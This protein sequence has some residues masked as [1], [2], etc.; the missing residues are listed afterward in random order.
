MSSGSDELKLALEKLAKLQRTNTKEIVEIE[1]LKS[2]NENTTELQN[3]SLTTLKEIHELQVQITDI[4]TKQV[5]PENTIHIH[6]PPELSTVERE[7]TP[8][9]KQSQDF[10]DPKIVIDQLLTD[11]EK[12]EQDAPVH[13]IIYKLPADPMLKPIAN[14][15]SFNAEEKQSIT[16]QVDAASTIYLLNQMITDAQR[17]EWLSKAVI[18]PLKQLSLNTEMSERILNDESLKKAFLNVLLYGNYFFGYEKNQTEKNRYSKLFKENMLILDK[19]LGS[20]NIEVLLKA[21]ADSKDLLRM[22]PLA[23]GE[24]LA[25]D[26]LLEPFRTAEIFGHYIPYLVAENPE[27]IKTEFQILNQEDKLIESYKIKEIKVMTADLEGKLIRDEG[28]MGSILVPDNLETAEEPTVYICFK[29]TDSTATALADIQIRAGAESYRKSERQILEQIITELKSYQAQLPVGK[30]LKIVLAGHSLGGAY[31]QLCFTSLQRILAQEIAASDEELKLVLDGI[32]Q[33]F[34]EKETL[35]TGVNHQKSI[36]DLVLDKNKIAGLSLCVANPAGVSNSV[37]DFSNALSSILVENGIYQKG[38]YLKISGDVVG[39]TGQGILSNVPDNKAEVSVLHIDMGTT[40]ALSTVMGVVGAPSTAMLLS[41]QAAGPVGLMVGGT[42][43]ALA[44]ARAVYDKN[45]SHTEYQFKETDKPTNAYS[46]YCSHN[47]DGTANI[48]DC[49]KIS[50]Q[51]SN[52]S[53]LVNIGS[54]LLSSIYSNQIRT[55]T[56]KVIEMERFLIELSKI[57]EDPTLQDITEANLDFLTRELELAKIGYED[58]ILR[59]LELSSPE[60]LNR[61]NQ[62]GDTLLSAA[63]KNEKYNFAEE[64]LTFS[65]GKENKEDRIDL[66]M[67]NKEGKTPFILCLEKITNYYRSIGITEEVALLEK[68]LANKLLD[69]GVDLSLNNQAIQARQVLKTMYSWGTSGTSYRA[70]F[71]ELDQ[72]LRLLEQ[73]K[74]AAPPVPAVMLSNQSRELIAQKLKED[75]TPKKIVTKKPPPP[76]PRS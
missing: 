72:K 37:Q 61:Q 35:L 51:L 29:G 25:Q 26:Q 1:R 53:W 33:K 27:A 45:K 31:S 28:V 55:E 42:A 74:E 8:E 73:E 50:E 39:V 6:M 71:E 41:G 66:N 64:V 7:N 9:I 21:S 49:L 46:L 12:T 40:G 52:Q 62:A 76:P 15:K 47:A 70:F 17:I 30:K 67:P 54:S 10:Q 2:R 36:G 48:E 24:I 19:A 23:Y 5:E 13:T 44:V 18:E 34:I 14:L 57:T 32:E 43:L 4:L 22:I 68:K 65:S 58:R 60:Y 63:I 16:D 38:H 59:F 11:L 69:S 75:I 56:K 3:Q 20:E